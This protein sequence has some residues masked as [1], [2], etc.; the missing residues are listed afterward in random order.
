MAAGNTREQVREAYRKWRALGFP[1]HGYAIAHFPF[2]DATLAGTVD[3][4]LAGASLSLSDLPERDENMNEEIQRYL[5]WEDPDVRSLEIYL[6]AMDNVVE[7][8]KRC[9]EQG[10]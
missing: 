8:L 6:K 7:I 4:Y 1:G 10:T 3:R 5:N 2:Y 9:I